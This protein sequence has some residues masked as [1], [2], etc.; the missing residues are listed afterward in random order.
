MLETTCPLFYAVLLNR[1]GKVDGGQLNM[2]GKC[3]GEECQ[4]AHKCLV[5]IG[6]G[7]TIAKPSNVWTP[8]EVTREEKTSAETTQKE[9]KSTSEKT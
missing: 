4:W 3:L 2:Y 9:N 1:F 5:N 8:S 7:E 6:I